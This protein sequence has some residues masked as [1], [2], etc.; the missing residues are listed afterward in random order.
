MM[1]A[2]RVFFKKINIPRIINK[3]IKIKQPSKFIVCSHSLHYELEK[4]THEKKLLA[5]IT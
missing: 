1:T 2:F 5:Q 3:K 4:A